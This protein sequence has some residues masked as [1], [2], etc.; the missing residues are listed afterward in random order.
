[1]PG[2]RCLKEPPRLGRGREQM[3]DS[4]LQGL[5]RQLWVTLTGRGTGHDM[6]PRTRA[7]HTGTATSCWPLRGWA[8]DLTARGPRGPSACWLPWVLHLR[9]P[10]PAPPQERPFFSPICLQHLTQ[11]PPFLQNPAR[12]FGSETAAPASGFMSGEQECSSKQSETPA[13]IEFTF[14][15]NKHVSEETV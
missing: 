9:Q 13:L 14:S 6:G 8:S 12:R 10:P 2:A 3:A 4:V 1:M 5:S 7:A 11:K 15:N